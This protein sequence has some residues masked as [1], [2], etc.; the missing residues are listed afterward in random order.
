ML[1]ALDTY[2]TPLADRYASEEMLKIFSPNTRYRTWR[3]LWIALAEAQAELGLAITP[4]QIDEMRRNLDGIDYVRVAQVERELRHDV[5]AHITVFGELC[6][7]AKPIIHLGA[8][9]CYVTDNTDLI[10]MRRGLELLR[11]KLKQLL[12][13]LRDFALKWRSQPALAYTHLQPAQLTT[14]GKRAA[15]WAQDFLL[16]LE[17]LNERLSKLRFRGVKG[18][19]GTQASFLRLFGGDSARVEELDR[20]VSEKMGFRNVFRIT[21]QT[22]TRKVDDQ[23]LHVLSGMAQSAHKFTNDAR[24]LQSFGEMEEPFESNQVGSSAMPYK[25]NPMRLE[26]ISSLSKFILCEALNPG[27]IH[28]TQWFERTL[29]DS[30]NRRLSIPQTFLA[31]D[32]ILILAVN[33]VRGLKVY[34]EVI[35]RRISQEFPF[36]ISED[37][38]MMAVAAGGDRQ[39]LHEC[40]RLH[41]MKVVEARRSEGARNDL[42]E[43]L[44]ADPLFGKVRQHMDEFADPTRHVGRAPEQV[45]IFFREEVAPALKALGTREPEGELEVRV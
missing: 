9:S 25:R 30:A 18:T 17:D 1:D 22:Y 5:M 34:P 3:K 38:L 20:R 29:D 24:I 44:A 19:T 2:Q 27:W 11:Q 4:G 41:A 37:L 7:S 45:E 32:A 15:M 14:V 10:L 39:V 13:A 23:I 35:R 43:R 33:V 42:L 8:T 26:R 12:E 36:M 16:D 28:A 40:I 6:P 31:A 21:G